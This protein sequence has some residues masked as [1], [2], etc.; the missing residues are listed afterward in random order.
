MKSEF[1][2]PATSGGRSLLSFKIPARSEEFYSDIFGLDNDWRW[3]RDIPLST[4]VLFK[5][6]IS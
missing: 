4:L 5:R 2:T 1:V 6:A 3:S